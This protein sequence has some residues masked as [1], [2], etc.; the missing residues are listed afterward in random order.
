MRIDPV[1]M[2]YNIFYSRRV[3]VCVCCHLLCTLRNANS[4]SDVTDVRTIHLVPPAILMFY[5][6]LCRV[7]IVPYGF[8][9]MISMRDFVCVCCHL[10]C[11]LRNANS[12]SDVTYVRTIHLVSPA[13]RIFYIWPCR[14]CIVPY[15][16]MYMI[17]TMH[18]I[19]VAA[20]C[21]CF[22]FVCLV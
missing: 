9:Y 8:M 18:P 14:V 16:F 15:E 1:E 19:R 17:M 2:Y 6:I 3:F 20:L 5:N 21:V 12:L 11:A 13:T 22:S 10:L 7:C 4:L